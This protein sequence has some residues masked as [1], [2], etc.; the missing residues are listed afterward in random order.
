MRTALILLSSAAMLTLLLQAIWRRP[1]TSDADT[2]D[3]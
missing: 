3:A 2:V 1:E